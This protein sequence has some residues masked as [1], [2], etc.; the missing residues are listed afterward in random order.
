MSEHEFSLL[1]SLKSPGKLAVQILCPFQLS[2][3]EEF[4]SKIPKAGNYFELL[5]SYIRI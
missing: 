4:S 2:G 3:Q 1:F 5:L